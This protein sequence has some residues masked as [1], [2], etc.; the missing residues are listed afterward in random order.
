MYQRRLL[1]KRLGDDPFVGD[2]KI[3]EQE[4]GEGSNSVVRLA[5][6]VDTGA[7][8]VAKIL[9]KKVPTPNNSPFGNSPSY[10][11]M[12]TPSGSPMGISPAVIAN[13]QSLAQK[14]KDETLREI[15]IMNKLRH[16]NIINTLQVLE[17]S[18]YL[19]LFMELSSEGDLYSYIQRHGAFEESRARHLFKQM[20]QAVSFC[21][22]AKVCHHDIKLE[23]FILDSSDNIK[24]IDFGYAIDFTTKPDSEKFHI[25]NGSPAYSAPEILERK[26]HDESVDIFSVGICLYYMMSAEYP[27]CDEIRTTYEQLVRN[28]RSLHFVWPEH[29]S[30]L[31]RDLLSH[32]IS[33]P[34]HRYQ[35]H[36]ILS[37]PWL[38]Q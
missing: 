15:H 6:N 35:W 34:S 18:S 38:T 2:Y 8:V 16:V 17:E 10:S 21:H 19:F 37:H 26:G 3:L 12:S 28:V 36:H 29:F 32:M 13:Y 9:I 25:F 31:L 20:A 30:P 24:L 22:Q 7:R 23:N 4:I 5:E 33:K 11:P 27:F 1:S 14:M